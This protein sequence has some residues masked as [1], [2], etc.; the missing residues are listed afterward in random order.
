MGRGRLFHCAR[1]CLECSEV[2]E[3]FVPGPILPVTP[4]LRT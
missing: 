2:G 1:F 4:L 3:V